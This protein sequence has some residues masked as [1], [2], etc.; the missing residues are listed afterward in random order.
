M[1]KKY[2]NAIFVQKNVISFKINSLLFEVYFI[3]LVDF[4]V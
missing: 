4:Y 1:Y 3:N 2:L